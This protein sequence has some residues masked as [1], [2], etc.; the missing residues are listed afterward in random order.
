MGVI[1]PKYAKATDG[2]KKLFKEEALRPGERGFDELAGLFIKRAS[3]LSTN[4]P[5]KELAAILATARVTNFTMGNALASYPDPEKG[6]MHD[7]LARV[8]LTDGKEGREGTWPKQSIAQDTES[9][10]D[11]NLLVLSI[12]ISVSGMLCSILSWWNKKRLEL[13]KD[14]RSTEVK[15]HADSQKEPKYR[16]PE[17]PLPY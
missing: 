13:P 12:S 15:Q 5:P 16:D 4:I 14:K 17:S 10:K 6:E 7:R 8:M 9:L 2:A 3:R 1:S 11:A